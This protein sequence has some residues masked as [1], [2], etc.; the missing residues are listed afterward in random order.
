M[1]PL[2]ASSITTV[3]MAEDADTVKSSCFNFRVVCF[4]YFPHFFLFT[5]LTMVFRY[6][7]I[8]YPDKGNNLSA[9]DYWPT[10]Y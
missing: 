2:C 5:I 6:I 3:L 9:L 7:M 10:Y 4:L 8:I 1:V